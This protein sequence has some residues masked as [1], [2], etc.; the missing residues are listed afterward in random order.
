MLRGPVFRQFL[1]KY[2]DS[3]SRF[4]GDVEPLV[5]AMMDE[6]VV[7]R[8][9]TA[10]ATLTDDDPKVVLDKTI[11]LLRDV[12]ERGVCNEPWV[13][14]ADGE[15]VIGEHTTITDSGKNNVLMHDFDEENPGPLAVWWRFLVC[16]SMMTMAE[17]LRAFI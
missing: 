8:F 4:H 15:T 6:T 1:I 2:S 9:A 11:D 16:K 5:H 12:T 13:E 17:A 10:V 14:M 3:T 7:G